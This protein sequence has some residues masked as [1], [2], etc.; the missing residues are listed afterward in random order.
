MY[1]VGSINNEMLYELI[2]EF[3]SDVS[4]RFQDVDKRFELLQIDTNRQFGELREL[5]KEEK[6]KLQQVY[7]SR[8]KI[9][10]SF[11]RAWMCGS[12]FIALI[13]STIVLAITK[14]F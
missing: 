5:I 13:S 4:R 3:K 12:F 8:D 14:A 9:T 1:P 10:V 7:E 11:T 2:K 6:Q